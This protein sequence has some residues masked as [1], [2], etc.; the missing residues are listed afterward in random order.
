MLLILKSNYQ[1]ITNFSLSI[2]FR[3]Q[4]FVKDEKEKIK[5]SYKKIQNIIYMDNL[6]FSNLNYH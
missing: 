1:G 2:W 4:K 6:P 3:I 5:T